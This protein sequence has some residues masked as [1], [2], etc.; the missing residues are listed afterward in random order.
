LINGAGFH[1]DQFPDAAVQ[2]L[3]PMR[4]HEA[5]VF[6]FVP[7]AATALRAIASTSSTCM[8]MRQN[9]LVH[10]PAARQRPIEASI[11]SL[12]RLIRE[13]PNAKSRC[14]R[15]RTDYLKR[16]GLNNYYQIV[17]RNRFHGN[18][19]LEEF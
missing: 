14:V 5:V 3:I 11:P 9:A 16:K 7:P 12:L 13:Y 19:F 17:I 1:V 18:P 15:H 6:E 2:I 10:K 4:I 8:A